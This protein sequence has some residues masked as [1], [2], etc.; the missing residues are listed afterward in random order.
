MQSSCWRKSS[1]HGLHPRQPPT[2][3]PRWAPGLR[4]GDHSAV[5]PRAPHKMRSQRSWWCMGS[6]GQAPHSEWLCPGGWKNHRLPTQHMDTLGFLAAKSMSCRIVANDSVNAS[7][8]TIS[9]SKMCK[10]QAKPSCSPTPIS[11]TVCVGKG[12]SYSWEGRTPSLL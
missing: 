4:P 1:R 9:C 5:T 11:Q 8:F 6:P 10:I 2:T 7:L 12:S 3:A